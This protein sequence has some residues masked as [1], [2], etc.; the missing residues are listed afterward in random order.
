MLPF[1]S[2]NKLFLLSMRASRAWRCSDTPIAL[3]SAAEACWFQPLGHTPL[4]AWSFL[5]LYSRAAELSSCIHA[6][7][8]SASGYSS[9]AGRWC[10]MTGRQLE[11]STSA[12]SFLNPRRSRQ[13]NRMLT[14]HRRNQHDSSQPCRLRLATDCPFA[15]RY[16]SVPG[17]KWP[18]RGGSQT[19]EG[20]DKSKIS[21]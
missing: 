15:A 8:V 3:Q 19:A 18:C 16:G 10:R 9:K 1:P 17:D 21:I 6:G 5:K 13:P 12:D 2:E 14:R 4:P 11:S 7:A 20:L